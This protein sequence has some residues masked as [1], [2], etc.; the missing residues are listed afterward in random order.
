MFGSLSKLETRKD[1]DI[2]LT[3]LGRFKKKINPEKY[4]KKLGRKIQLFQF[5]SIDEIKSKEL[6]MNVLNGYIIEGE[7][8]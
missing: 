2:D 3:I 5:K 6:K 7:I 1:S 4:E 8:G